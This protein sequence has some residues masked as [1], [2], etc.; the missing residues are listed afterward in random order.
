MNPNCRSPEKLSLPPGVIPPRRDN[1]ALDRDT[2]RDTSGTEKQ[3]SEKKHVSAGTQSGTNAGHHLLRAGR[4][5]GQCFP[6]CA[7]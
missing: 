6:R 7:T 3:N 2:G 4:G 1:G 5:A